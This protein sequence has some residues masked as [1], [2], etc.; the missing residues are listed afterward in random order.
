MPRPCRPG[1]FLCLFQALNEVVHALLAGLFHLLRH[2]A[3]H[4]QGEAGRGMAQVLL[5]GLDVV[6]F[7]QGGNGI[8]MAQIVEAAFGQADGGRQALVV[9]KH[10]LNSQMVPQC[11]RKYQIVRIVP[12]L[13]RL[14]APQGFWQAVQAHIIAGIFGSL[15]QAFG[16]SARKRGFPSC[17][18]S[19]TI[20]GL[21]RFFEKNIAQMAARKQY[22]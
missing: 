21:C 3:V 22:K 2:M 1:L 16:I 19:Q 8:S 4:I 15:C 11:I 17:F 5:C 12:R 7:L 10:C 6:A 20:S 13:A 14:D 9:K 18:L